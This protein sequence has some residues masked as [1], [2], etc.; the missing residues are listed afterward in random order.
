MYQEIGYIEEQ[1][2]LP[3]IVS[4]KCATC[5]MGYYEFVDGDEK[6]Y[7]A[8]TA[9]PTEGNNYKHKCTNEECENIVFLEEIYPAIEYESIENIIESVSY[10]DKA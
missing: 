3:I 10:K 4:L 2:M 1:V 6:T 5:Q 9:Y 7:T 8:S